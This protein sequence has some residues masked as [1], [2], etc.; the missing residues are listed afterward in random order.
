MSLII[1][2]IYFQGDPGVPGFK[3]EA[4]PKG[5]PVSVQNV[6]SRDRASRLKFS[7]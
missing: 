1:D 4:G 5:E 6:A 2:G 7:N 3:G